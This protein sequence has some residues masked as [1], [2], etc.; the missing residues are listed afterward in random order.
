MALHKHLTRLERLAGDKYS[1]LIW[2]SVNYGCNE[3]Y[4]TG[5]GDYKLFE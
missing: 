4:D 2:I 1:S 3:F 5:P